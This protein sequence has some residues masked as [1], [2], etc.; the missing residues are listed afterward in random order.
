MRLCHGVP[1]ILA[2]ALT[3]CGYGDEHSRVGDL[4]EGDALK[5]V[6][7]Q[8]GSS[9]TIAMENATQDGACLGLADRTSATANGVPAQI[10]PGHEEDDEF[11]TD[12][13]CPV[14]LWDDVSGLGDPLDVLI[15]D[16][17]RL[18]GDPY[19]SVSLTFANP[20]SLPP[21]AWPGATSPD[22]VHSISSGDHIEL[23]V[24][25]GEVVDSAR[26]TV[27]VIGADGLSTDLARGDARVDGSRVV[28][29]IGSLDPAGS[30]TLLVDMDGQIVVQGCEHATCDA[31]YFD[32]TFFA[33]DIP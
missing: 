12:V 15:V 29:D 14:L 24:P 9:L 6:V 22:E 16:K 3:A 33:V 31:W 20:S 11:V 18:A 10:R 17:T 26:W 8:G 21:L 7:G 5:L 4:L 27:S 2:L 30:G 1:A 23:A 19:G 32:E 25:A 13:D 28:I